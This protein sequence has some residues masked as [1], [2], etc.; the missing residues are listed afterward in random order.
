[1]VA[2]APSNI[3]S[4]VTSVEELAAWSLSILAEVAGNTTIQTDRNTLE[5]VATAQTFRFANEVTDKERL[6]L[7]AYLPLTTSWR[8]SGKFW[9]GG[10]GT[11]STAAIPAGYTA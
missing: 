6:V 5:P 11:L 4:S 1:M 8:G 9:E 3:P 2:F 10:I 7:A